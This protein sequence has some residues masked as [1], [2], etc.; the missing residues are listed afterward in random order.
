MC[1]RDRTDS[2]NFE[3]NDSNFSFKPLLDRHTLDLIVQLANEV[4]LF[5]EVLNAD[6]VANRYASDTLQTVTSRNNTKLVLL[7]DKL[8]SHDVISY[9]WQ[10]VIAK[11]RLIIS[12]SGKKCLNQH[13]MSST[14]NR[15]KDISPNITEKQLLA[16][17]DK[18]IDLIKN[19]EV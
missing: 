5:K 3:L 7:L 11:K 16:V 19:R 9:N 10:S 4:S 8:A 18:Y 15:I 13:D 17:I 12:S 1:I 2:G 6:N 14:L